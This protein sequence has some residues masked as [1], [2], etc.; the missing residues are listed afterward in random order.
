MTPLSCR[1]S[2]HYGTNSGINVITA[3]SFNTTNSV[4]RETPPVEN[5]QRRQMATVARRN[6]ILHLQGSTFPFPGEEDPSFS[7]C[8]A[9]HAWTPCKSPAR[10]RLFRSCPP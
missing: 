10:R 3:F 4:P 1:L 2:D 5:M 8:P 6:D 9:L 7:G